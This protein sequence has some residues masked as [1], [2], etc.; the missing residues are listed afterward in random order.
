MLT[1][2]K[3]LGVLICSPEVDLAGNTNAKTFGQ[4]NSSFFASHQTH[5]NFFWAQPKHLR[6]RLK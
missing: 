2:L 3:D 1:P 6:A 5:L 4:C